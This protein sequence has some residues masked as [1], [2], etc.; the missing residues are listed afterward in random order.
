MVEGD[1]T[2]DMVKV[3][4]LSPMSVKISERHKDRMDGVTTITAN[5]DGK[6]GHYSYVSARDGTTT[7]YTMNKQ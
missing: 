4:R 6:T 1:P 5:A 3:E 2:G 7:G